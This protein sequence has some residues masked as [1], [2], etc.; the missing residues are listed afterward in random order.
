METVVINEDLF[1]RALYLLFIEKFGEKEY[2]CPN[3][4]KQIT[5]IDFIGCD[6]EKG[7]LQLKCPYCNEIHTFENLLKNY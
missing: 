7:I 3:T 1:Q 4:A 5:T 6:F 2:F